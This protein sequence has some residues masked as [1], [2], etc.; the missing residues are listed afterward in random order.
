MVKTDKV[1]SAAVKN[2]LNAI[3]KDFHLPQGDDID[4]RPYKENINHLYLKAPTVIR[5]SL[6]YFIL[7][8]MSK[9]GDGRLKNWCRDLALELTEELE[10]I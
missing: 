8:T 1:F 5:A 4:F 10:T 9:Y 3:S 2:Y 6:L 7:K